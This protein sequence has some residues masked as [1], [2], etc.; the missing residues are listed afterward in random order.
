MKQLILSISLIISALPILFGQDTRAISRENTCDTLFLKTG[1]MRLV[2]IV[3]ENDKMISYYNCSEDNFK[4][5]GEAIFIG[6]DNVQAVKKGRAPYRVNA[7][8]PRYDT[9]IYKK[10]LSN[11]KLYCEVNFGLNTPYISIIFANLKLKPRGAEYISIGAS[12]SLSVGYQFQ[13]YVGVGL[14]VR[15]EYILDYS[16]QTVNSAFLDYR[17]D[18]NKTKVMFHGGIVMPNSRFRGEYCKSIVLDVSRP[19][20]IVGITAKRYFWNHISVGLN[21]FYSK[22]PTDQNCFQVS[23]NRDVVSKSELDYMSQN[24]VLGLNFPARHKKVKLYE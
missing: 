24:I 11:A 16:S 23:T 19:H 17:L 9:T 1:K 2:R 3:S 20:S 15:S 7:K 18:F 5:S 13:K 12:A 6:V 4:S 22:V 8:I 21:L 14:T 10:V